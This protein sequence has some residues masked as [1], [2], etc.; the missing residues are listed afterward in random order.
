VRLI[1]IALM[2]A[3]GDPARAPASPTSLVVQSMRST[4]RQTAEPIDQKSVHRTSD[5]TAQGNAQNLPSQNVR[6][7]AFL[8]AIVPLI[9]V[10]NRPLHQEEVSRSLEVVL[11]VLRDLGPDGSTT[12]GDNNVKGWHV[13]LFTNADKYAL[14]VSTSGFPNKSGNIGVRSVETV[15]L[16]LGWS[17]VGIITHPFQQFTYS[18]GCRNIRIEHDNVNIVRFDLFNVC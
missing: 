10:T 1:G 12:G 6:E 15:L 18:S 8:A 9:E 2:I 17:R 4:E 16:A 13:E 3:A 5:R 11:T 7:T 14:T